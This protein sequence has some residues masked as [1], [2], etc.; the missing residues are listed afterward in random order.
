MKAGICQC[1]CKQKCNP[2][3]RFKSGHSF[4]HRVRG[5]GKPHKN[6]KVIVEELKMTATAALEGE[7][8]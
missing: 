6:P 3:R 7:T 1:G 2:K 8:K 4:E 5:N